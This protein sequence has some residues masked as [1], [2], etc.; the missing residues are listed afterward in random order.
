MATSTQKKKK[1]L[2]FLS[3]Y[4]LDSLGGLDLFSESSS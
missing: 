3:G 1:V 2:H 4:F